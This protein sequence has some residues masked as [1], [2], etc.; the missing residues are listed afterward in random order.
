MRISYKTDIHQRV[1]CISSECYIVSVSTTRS[2]NPHSIHT[3]YIC[4][5][6]LRPSLEL[7]QSSTDNKCSVMFLLHSYIIKVHITRFV[8]VNVFLHV[9]LQEYFYRESNTDVLE[10]MVLLNLVMNKIDSIHSCNLHQNTFPTEQQEHNL[11]MYLCMNLKR[12]KY[13][14]I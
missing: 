3:F 7:R 11:N 10:C 5:T 13:N 6:L 2:N 4:T 14:F 12:V 9:N 8:C 1:C